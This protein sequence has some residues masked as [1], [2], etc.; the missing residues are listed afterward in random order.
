L[1]ATPA[2][3]SR[4]PCKQAIFDAERGH[5]DLVVRQLRELT[6]TLEDDYLP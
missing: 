3:V 4:T 2:S 1:T 5:H 6:T